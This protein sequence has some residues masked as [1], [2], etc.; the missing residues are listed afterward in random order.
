MTAS[1]RMCEF[2]NDRFAATNSLR[3]ITGMGTSETVTVPPWVLRGH[4]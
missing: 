3:A 2:A 1:G 4:P